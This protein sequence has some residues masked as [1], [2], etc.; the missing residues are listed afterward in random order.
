MRWL[1][2]QVLLLAACGDDREVPQGRADGSTANMLAADAGTGN[3]MDDY[4][5]ARSFCA[6]VPDG[7]EP[8]T[9]QIEACQLAVIDQYEGVC[10]PPGVACRDRCSIETETAQQLDQCQAGCPL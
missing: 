7:G 9:E 5:L 3:C 6:V 2:V 8:N 1:F 4:F 10:L